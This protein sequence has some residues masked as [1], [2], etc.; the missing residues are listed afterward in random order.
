MKKGRA[1]TLCGKYSQKNA[2]EF[3][4]CWQSTTGHAAY[5]QA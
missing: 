5:T 1:L 3:V 2:T 4:S